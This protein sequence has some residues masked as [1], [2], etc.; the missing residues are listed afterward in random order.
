[1]KDEKLYYREGKFEQVSEFREKETGCSVKK[2]INSQFVYTKQ[3]KPTTGFITEQKNYDESKN[4]F[5]PNL[6][7][8]EEIIHIAL[9]TRPNIT[10]M[11]EI[12]KIIGPNIQEFLNNI[13]FGST[14]ILAINYISKKWGFDKYATK[15]GP[16]KT[17]LN[18]L[19]KAFHLLSGERADYFSKNMQA[20]GGTHCND[21]DA[22]AYIDKCYGIGLGQKK[23]VKSL[24]KDSELRNILQPQSFVYIVKD[25]IYDIKSS[26]IKHDK[27]GNIIYSKHEKPEKRYILY[28]MPK[29]RKRVKQEVTLLMKDEQFKDHLDALQEVIEH[30]PTRSIN[31]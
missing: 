24:P 30:Y 16:G 21:E 1:M 6:L 13:Y 2:N 8:E 29:L 9:Y 26:Y 28:D 27:N 11:S 25:I 10:G 5:Y 20:N 23:K 12:S 17:P 18:I 15:G 22:K 4:L 19:I 14:G 31:Q 7:T 3:D